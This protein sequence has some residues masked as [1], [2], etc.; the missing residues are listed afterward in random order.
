MDNPIEIKLDK[1]RAYMR[2]Y[3]K[4]RYNNDLEGSR[5]YK[6]S[7]KCRITNNLPAEEL[8]EYGKYL[9]DIHKLRKIKAK[10]PNDLFEKIIAE[11]ET[12]LEP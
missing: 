2:E 11:Q 5:A 4:K 1:Q 10:L 3:M 12:F 8:Q 6:N 7:V 9:V